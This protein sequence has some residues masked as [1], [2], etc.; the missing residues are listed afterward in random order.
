MVLDQKIFYFFYQLA[1]LNGWL[2]YFWIFLADYL[3]YFLIFNFLFFV[4]FSQ[5]AGDWRKRWF[6]FG[7]TVLT[8]ILSRGIFTALI[9]F[10][11]HRL[12]PFLVFNIDPLIINNSNAFPSGHAAFFFALSLI[13]FFYNKR[14]GF[15]TLI[16]SLLIGFARIASGVHWPSD[17]LGGFLVALTAVWLA[18]LIIAPFD[19]KT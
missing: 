2:D 3:G 6:I 19:K 8:L 15:W 4:F 1:H 18:R 10:F 5:S 16:G 13:L 12:R 17:I 9:K 11:Y 7:S 14:I